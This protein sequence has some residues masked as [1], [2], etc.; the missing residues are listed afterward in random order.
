MA[1]LNEIGV[2]NQSTCAAHVEE[3]IMEALKDVRKDTLADT[4]DRLRGLQDFELN[5]MIEEDP[6]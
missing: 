6:H 2:G 1:L 3:L 4:R 5:R